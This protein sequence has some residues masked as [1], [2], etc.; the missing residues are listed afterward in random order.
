VIFFEAPAGTTDD[1]YI[2]I[3]DADTGG[4]IDEQFGGWNTTVRYT[5]LG[6]PGAYT[7]ADARS[8][9]PGPAGINSGTLLA[10]TVIGENAAYDAQWVAVFGPYSADAG[11]SAG[12]SRVFKLV[13]E[14]AGGDDGNL[15]NVA[16]STGPLTSTA[17]AGS[18]AFAY[19]WTF[20][21]FSS[22]PRRLYPYLLSGTMSFEQHNFDMDNLCT[23]TVHT[24]IRDFGV[25]AISGDGVE[26]WSSY[27]VDAMEGGATWAVTMAYLSAGWNDLTF[28]TAGDGVDLAIFIHPTTA[29]PP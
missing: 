6:G 20:P 16:L 13:V 3:F 29:P 18:R 19:S 7:H 5:L 2:R 14:G 28:W 12:S 17:P 11:E 9:H 22:S 4:T 21:L 15:Y 27:G 8:S 25:D 26:A 10:Q 1:L 23:I 24:P